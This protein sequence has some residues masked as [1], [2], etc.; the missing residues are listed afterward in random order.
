MFDR[1]AVVG[2]G[3]IGTLAGGYLT[4]GGYD[5]TVVPIFRRSAVER[6]NTDGIRIS[7]EGKG[8]ETPVKAA[9]IDDLAA[10]EVFDLVLITGKSN[11]T[12]TMVRK[13]LPHLAQDGVVS[14]LQNGINEEVIIPLVGTERVIPTVCFTGGFSPEAGVVENHDG[15]L[16]TGELDGADTPRVHRLAE[17][18]S[19]IKPTTV[20]DNIMLKRWEKLAEICMGVPLS[21][22]SGYSQ[23]C[24]NDD[25]RMQRMFGRLASETFRV[26]RACGYPLRQIAFM[27]EAEMNIL[28]VRDDAALA[29]RIA[30]HPMAKE[31]PPEGATGLAALV[32]AYTADIRRGR[33][34]EIY[35]ANG[36][37]IEKGKQTGVQTPGQKAVVEMVRQI[38]KGERKADRS[39]L[40][41]LIAMTDIYYKD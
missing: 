1:I 6:L 39:N 31:A 13:M 9:F 40:D 30:H 5:V 21:C 32:D 36:Y 2:T 24:G 23:F 18:L 15:F 16:V 20:S 27:T 33:P 19:A 12:E 35:Y 11:D 17:I 38:E 29:D 4:L 7:F 10:D 34:L 14:S 41:E 28:A 26:A 3:V 25:P 22:V 37:I 8:Y